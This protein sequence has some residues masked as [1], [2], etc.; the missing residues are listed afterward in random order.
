ML[1]NRLEYDNV[2][3]N[4]SKPILPFIKY[5]KNN[6]GELTIL[7]PLE[8]EPY[9]TYPD[10]TAQSVYLSRTVQQCVIEDM[11]NELDFI[12]LYDEL[13]IEIQ[14]LVDMP[15][16]MINRFIMFLHQNKGVFP[17]RRREEFNK[18]TDNEIKRIEV[19]Y[20]NLVELQ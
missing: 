4:Y 2:L 12:Q 13:K 16:K 6:A 14:Q 8:I 9:Y 11:P 1:N 10:L 7:N 19:I 15:D 20:K 18:L 17:K 5:S 3:E